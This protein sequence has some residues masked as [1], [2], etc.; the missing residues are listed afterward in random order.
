[1]ARHPKACG[2]EA[3]AAVENPSRPIR[4][5]PAFARHGGPSWKT[6]LKWILQIRVDQLRQPC[7]GERHSH[8]RNCFS[9][10]FVRHRQSEWPVSWTDRQHVNIVLCQLKALYD[11]CAFVGNLDRLRIGS[12]PRQPPGP[13]GHPILTLAGGLVPITARI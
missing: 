9:F 3:G 8:L 11:P 10:G 1:M 13:A 2:P 5:W 12:R 4:I 6:A 7:A